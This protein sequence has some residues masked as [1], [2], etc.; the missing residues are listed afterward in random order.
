MTNNRINNSIRN[1]S[2]STLLHF[3]SIIIS[4]VSRT[5]FIKVLGEHFLGI[6][7]LYSN[8]LQLLSLAD[9][10]ITTAFV[11]SLYKPLASKDFSVV[12][13][14]LNYF[15]KIF[16]GIALIILALGFL[17]VPLLPYIVNG[18]T[19]PLTEIQFYFILSVLNISVS[20]L[21]IYKSSLIKADQNEYIIKIVSTL[22]T[23][24]MHILQIVILFLTQNYYL[25]LCVAVAT[26]LLNNL[27][28]TIIV[29]KKY[30]LKKIIAPKLSSEQKKS[31]ISSVFSVALYKIGAVIINSTDNILISIL[32][33][34]V[35]VGY[36]S[37][38]A[39]LISI[40]TAFVS[41]FSSALLGSIGNLGA[42]NNPDKTK[43]IFHVC[44]LIY[45]AI[46][47]FCS[48]CLIS[49]L[50]DFVIIWLNDSQYV[51]SQ[52][53][54]IM[55]VFSF[56]ITTISNPL[57]MFRESLGI[58]S[59]VKYIMFI[60][61]IINI[62][63][64]VI[65]GHIWG[66]GGIIFATGLSRILT[67]FWYEPLFLYKNKFNSSCVEYWKRILYYALQVLI[68]LVCGY[69]IC[70]VIQGTTILLLLFKTL[71]CGLITCVVFVLFNFKTKEGKYLISIAKKI[72]RR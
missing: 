33:G 53:H 67:L 60:A 19:I 61:S 8:I 22:T 41:I 7:G 13:S 54:V 55:F 56:Y 2:V 46:G 5:I 43:K 71:I 26:T 51:L 24:L 50:N 65:F 1:I 38:Y 4:F 25:F 47:A 59:S 44:L 28:L 14:Y 15:R 45:H 40:V 18:S 34:T 30:N 62:I 20:Y 72:L 64:S 63:L 36:Y 23:I 21:G 32:L 70:S 58:F 69:L 42:E 31:S 3:L 11:Y 6:N 52:T 57:W 16:Y 10:G 29:N 9:L 48:L 35:I 17:F 39:M 49:L 27:I 68:V 12:S 37:N 66:L